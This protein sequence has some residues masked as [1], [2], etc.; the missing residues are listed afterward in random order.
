[1]PVDFQELLNGFEFTDLNGGRGDHQVFICKRTG[2]IYWRTGSSDLD[3]D[4]ELP[5]DIEDDEKYLMLPNRRDLDLG[6]PLIWKFVRT[7][8][9]DHVDEVREIFSRKG[10]YR[11][12]RE[13]LVR[14]GSL[15]RWY[16]FESSAKE[17][18][19]RDWCA[20][21]AIELVG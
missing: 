10:A 14:T 9:P 4:E 11:R 16:D 2:K 7:H 1:M 20:T 19:L 21:H 18:A 17:Q 13:L 6:Q 8:L 3:E 12:Y 5:E 15:D